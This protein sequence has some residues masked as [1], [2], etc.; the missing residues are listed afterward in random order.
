MIFPMLRKHPL[1]AEFER[2]SIASRPTSHAEGLRIFDAMVR[3][4]IAL[5]VLPLADPLEGI[6]ADL[7]LARKLKGDREPAR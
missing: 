3:E 5:G 7:E 4:A 6:E 1:L 2:W